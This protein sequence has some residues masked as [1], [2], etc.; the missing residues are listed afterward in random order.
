MGKLPQGIFAYKEKRRCVRRLCAVYKWERETQKCPP[1]GQCTNSTALATTPAIM[2]NLTTTAAH[3]LNP[4]THVN[5]IMKCI[6]DGGPVDAM[7][8][9]YSDFDKREDGVYTH[10]TGSYKGLHCGSGGGAAMMQAGAITGLY[11]IAGG[12]FGEIWRVFPH[13]KRR[14]RGGIERLMYAGAAEIVINN[15]LSQQFLLPCCFVV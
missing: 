7:F 9:V 14:K 15:L 8:N 5:E 13:S 12:G 10:K 1:N 11:R 3:F 6:L 2:L 4:S